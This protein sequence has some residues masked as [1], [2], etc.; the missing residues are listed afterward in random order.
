MFLMLIRQGHLNSHLLIESCFGETTANISVAQQPPV[1]FDQELT[2]ASTSFIHTSTSGTTL[3]WNVGDATDDTVSSIALQQSTNGGASFSNIQVGVGTEVTGYAVDPSPGQTIFRIRQSTLII[4]FIIRTT[5]NVNNNPAPNVS[6]SVNVSTL[7][8]TYAI[9]SGN[10]GATISWSMSAGS[11]VS[12]LELKQVAGSV[13]ITNKRTGSVVFTG[14]HTN[15]SGTYNIPG[16]E[17]ASGQDTEFEVKGITIDDEVGTDSVTVF[18][19]K[20][21]SMFIQIQQ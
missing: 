1:D 19:K 16:S 5:I 15:S 9:Q 17:L 4:L 11:G 14:N 20:A 12:S 7:T 6:A 13:T 2:A 10:S 8:N 21:P 3:S 18:L